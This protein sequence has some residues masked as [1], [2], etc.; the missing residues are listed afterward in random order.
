MEEKEDILERE[1]INA[2]RARGLKEAMQ[3]WEEEDKLAQQKKSK[4][5]KKTVIALLTPVAIAA[6]LA[7]VVFLTPASWQRYA[8]RQAREYAYRIFPNRPAQRPAN[9]TFNPEEWYALAEP[10]LVSV[11]TRYPEYT[12]GGSNSLVYEAVEDMRLR[13]FHIA[14]STLQYAE[15][16]LSED[17]PHYQTISEDIDYLSALCEYML[18]NTKKA[19]KA[20]KAI[21]AGNGIHQADAKKLLTR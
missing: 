16:E 2:I 10:S 7:G 1:I 18:G 19:T 8:Y 12:P 17:D 11:A 5:W 9:T 14:L 20:L 4:R 21:A 3:R 15:E 6:M 13:N